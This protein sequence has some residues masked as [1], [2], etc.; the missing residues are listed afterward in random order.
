MNRQP[1]VRIFLAAVLAATPAPAQDKAGTSAPAPAAAIPPPKV[2]DTRAGRMLELVLRSIQN[3]AAAI[4]ADKFNDAFQ[5]AV[6]PDQVATVCAQVIDQHGACTLTALQPG[7]SPDILLATVTGSK[8]GEKF[9][10]VLGLD[11]DG[12]METLLFRPPANLDLPPFKDWAELDAALNALAPAKAPDDKSPPLPVSARVNFGAFELKAAGPDKPAGPFKPEPIHTLNPDLRLAIGSTFKLYVLGA[13]GEAVLAG[14]IKWDDPLPIKTEHKSLPSGTM[15]NEPEGAVFP[16]STYAEKMISISDNTATDHLIRRLSRSSIEDYMEAG[17][18]GG[19]GGGHGDPSLNHPFLLTR[20][21]FALKLSPDT[22]LM[23][24]W[25][26]AGEAGRRD[27]LVYDDPISPK[28]P[29]GRSHTPGEVFNTNPELAAAEKWTAGGPRHISTIEWFASP[30]DLARLFADLH[31]LELQPDN[32]PL[33]KALRLNPGIPFDKK[34]WTKV[35]FK[36]GSEPGVLNLTW[37]LERADGRLFILTFG[38]NNTRA[39]LDEKKL[40]EIAPRAI[41][42]LASSPNEPRT[43]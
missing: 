5:K 16:I 18:G 35:A 9:E 3:K 23:P 20:E 42:L 28:R 41:G 12:K 7:P 27:M 17:V 4:P 10:I 40:L 32:A 6:P 24:R 14:T 33:A 13:L 34:V 29:A 43:K 39:A 37:M 26:V 21:L 8:S 38:W 19:G 15:Q 31:R 1:L 2:P 22:T 25:E 11:K 36:G 30:T